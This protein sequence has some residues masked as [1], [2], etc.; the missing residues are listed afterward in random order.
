MTMQQDGKVTLMA[1][2]DVGPIYE[3]VDPLVEL[4]LPVLR[5]ADLRCTTCERVYTEEGA[6]EKRVRLPHG[7]VHPNLASIYIAGGFNV[8]SLASNHALDYR[9]VG[10]L[11]NLET[12][13]KLGITVFGTGKNLEEAR[14]PAFVEKNGVKIAFLGYCSIMRPQDPATKNKPG[15]TPI[16]VH[17]W[18]EPVDYQAA[19]PPRVMSL[20]YEEDME[21]M[22]EDVR[23]AKQQADVVIMSIHFGIHY[24]PKVIAMYQPKIVHAAIDA[25]ADLILGGHSHNPKAI[26]V[27]KGKVCFYSLSNFIMSN[28]GPWS[29]SLDVWGVPKNLDYPHMPYG[30]DAAKTCIAKLVISKR[31][32]ERASFIPTF[33]DT[34]LRPEPLKAEDP[35]FNELVKYWEWASD[36]FPHRFRVEGNEVVIESP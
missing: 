29:S 18:Y 3:P 16:R 23:K 12:F 32:V 31:G 8:V 15:Q 36:Q 13:D 11:H 7:V 9:E 6:K 1:V 20:P 30:M 21:A 10:V 33:I 2:G 26:E 28:P 5:Q 27:Y 17:T 14:K 19:T 34:Q 4:A 24:I 25:G 35:R 22:V